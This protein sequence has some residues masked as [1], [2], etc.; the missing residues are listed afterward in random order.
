M[1]PISNQFNGMV[2]TRSDDTY[3]DESYSAADAH[4]LSFPAEAKKLRS[5]NGVPALGSVGA[6]Q[7]WFGLFCYWPSFCRIDDHLSPFTST[8]YCH[9]EYSPPATHPLTCTHRQPATPPDTHHPPPPPPAF[10]NQC[11]RACLQLTD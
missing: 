8:P 10:A 2:R 9:T 11:P 7:P 5:L 1:I 4:V 6:V 3:L